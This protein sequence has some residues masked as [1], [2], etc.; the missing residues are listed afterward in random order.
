MGRKYNKK[1]NQEWHKISTWWWVR[2]SVCS[3]WFI[4]YR[5]LCHSYCC[6]H[7]WQAWELSSRVLKVTSRLTRSRIDRRQEVACMWVQSR[8]HWRVSAGPACVAVSAYCSLCS[9]HCSS[10][11]W[12]SRC[13]LSSGCFSTKTHWMVPLLQLHF[14]HSQLQLWRLLQQLFHYIEDRTDCHRSW[15]WLIILFSSHGRPGYCIVYDRAV[16]SVALEADGFFYL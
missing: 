5:W 9:R 16:Q 12:S 10:S 15:Y 2:M 14:F 1:T 11:L 3:I 6:M 8:E 4:S 7:R 13:L